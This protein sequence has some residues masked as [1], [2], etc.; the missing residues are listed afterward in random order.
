MEG[1]LIEVGAED[2]RQDPVVKVT[3]CQGG[4]AE[5]WI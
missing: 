1:I 3:C 2:P 5:D 4:V